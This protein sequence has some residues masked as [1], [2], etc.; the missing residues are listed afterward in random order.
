[1][2]LPPLVVD[3]RV[4]EREERNFRIWLPVFLLWPLLLVIVGFA[5]ILSVILDLVLLVAGARY[6][7]F[8]LLLVGALQLLAEAR[9][10][11]VHVNGHDATVV[12]VDIY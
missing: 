10:T 8:T 2:I 3:V 6:H 9:G 1:M 7:Y 5:L 11:H 12:D 4:R